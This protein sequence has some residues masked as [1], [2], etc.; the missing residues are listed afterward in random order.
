MRKG[1]KEQPLGMKMSL[2]KEE[3]TGGKNINGKQKKDMQA[4]EEKISSILE[5]LSY[6]QHS[7]ENIHSVGNVAVCLAGW[8][9]AEK[10]RS[11][12]V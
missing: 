1:H 10:E 3:N 12:S 11:E 4:F 2:L 6:Q 7:I 5:I 8:S 9:E